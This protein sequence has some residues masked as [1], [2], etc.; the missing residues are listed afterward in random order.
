M[1]TTALAHAFAGKLRAA[2]IEPI[3]PTASSMPLHPTRC[4]S[5]ANQSQLLAAG[6]AAGLASNCACLLAHPR[7]PPQSVCVK[8]RKKNMRNAFCA[9]PVDG[10]R[11]A[12]V[13][14]RP[15]APA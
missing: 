5:A 8:E 9:I 6:V 12:L 11:V 10:R 15:P 4:A 1:A 14:V 7:H 13:D 3:Y 2:S